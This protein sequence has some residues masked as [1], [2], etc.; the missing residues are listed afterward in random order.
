MNPTTFSGILII[1]IFILCYVFWLW[2]KMITQD[3]SRLEKSYRKNLEQIKE[4]KA[5][6]D[7]AIERMQ[8]IE[9]RAGRL[10]VKYNFLLQISSSALSNHFGIDESTLS[11]SLD[12]QAEKMLAQIE[13]EDNAN[14]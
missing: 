8:E 4:I 6:H 2:R 3:L 5:E 14:G 1:A 12:K 13:Q 11:N 9:K 10:V 7:A